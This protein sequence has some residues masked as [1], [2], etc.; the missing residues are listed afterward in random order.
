ME[1]LNIAYLIDS[2]GNPNAGTEG[3]FIKLVQGMSQRGHQVKV[4]ALRQSDYLTSGELGVE[5]EFLDVTRMAS[6]KALWKMFCL[7][8][9]LRAQ[10]TQLVQTFFNDASVIAPFFL[11]W[12][13]CRVMI[14][15]RDMGFW[16]SAN[17]LKLLRWNRRWVDAAVV[18]SKAVGEQTALAEHI[19]A[20]RV[21]VIYNG[22]APP[23][24]TQSDVELPA[25]PVIGIVANIRPIKRMQDAV[26]ALGALCGEFPDLQLVIVGGGDPAELQSQA[27]QLGVAKLLHCVGG[28]SAPQDYIRRFDIALLCSE[29]EG[30]SNAIIEYLQWGKPVVCSRTGGNPEIIE[31]G[32][33]GY[34]YDVGDVDA[35]VEHLRKL[36]ADH[37][38][39]KKMSQYALSSVASRFSMSQMLGNHELLY[40]QLLTVEDK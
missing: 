40:R 25:G 10:N 22:Y 19:P 7:G 28:Q 14:S 17:L 12:A 37:E 32:K 9:R 8:R 29:S 1:Q 27:E 20:E 6:P 23:A 11:K 31:H 39:Y 18:N 15:R 3:Q 4:Y 16:Y 5:V 36:L 2:L 34:L 13:G 30:F 26:A 21:H 35:L 24:E 38:G 33:N